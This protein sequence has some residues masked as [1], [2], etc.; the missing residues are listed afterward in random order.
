VISYP[1]RQIRLHERTTQ[2]MLRTFTNRTEGLAAIGARPCAA[3]HGRVWLAQQDFVST[4][5]PARRL[6][7]APT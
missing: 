5:K 2:T 6:P 3:M 1:G 4:G 7:G